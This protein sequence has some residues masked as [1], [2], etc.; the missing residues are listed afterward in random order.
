MNS[1]CADIILFPTFKWQISQPSLLHDTSDEFDK[2]VVNKFWIDIQ[3]RWGDYDSHDIQ[4]YA[5]AK[6]FEYTSDTMSLYP[7]PTGI[8]I[9]YDLAYNMCSA[10]GNW[11]PGLK[12]VVLEASN[13]ILKSNAALYVLRERV[14]KAL[15][16]YSSE[17]QVSYLNS[18]NYA[19]MFSDQT[20]W[21]I[22]DSNVYRVL[23]HK[24]L[25]GNLS[26]KPVNGVL[27]IFVPKTGRLFM[28]V[29]HTSVWAGQK[30]LGQLAK[31]KTAE[32]LIALMRPLPPEDQPKQIIVMR[33]GLL[34]PL[35]MNMIDFPNVIIKGSELQ[36]PFQSL[37]KLEIF[38]ETIT[39]A[40]EPKMILFNMYDDWLDTVSNYTAFSRLVLIMRALH[41]NADKT[42]LAMR[43]AASAPKQPNHIWPTLTQDEWPNVEIELRNIILADF[44]KSC[45][46]NISSLTQS[47]IKDIILGLETAKESINN[48][49]IEEIDRQRNEAMGVMQ[50]VTETVNKLGEKV[51]VQTTTPY[52]QQKFKSQ[53]DWRNRAIAST[54]LN[55]R[56]NNISVNQVD[57]QTK[58]TV[59][60]E[61]MN[62]YVFAKNV[63]KRFI[64]ITDLKT[65]IAGL[66]FG[67]T[68]VIKKSAS[69]SVSVKEIRVILMVPQIGTFHSVNF[70][71]F[72]PTDN[73]ELEGLE[74]L[75]WIHTQANETSVLSPF[76]VVASAKIFESN[77][78]VELSNFV[79]ITVSFPPGVCSL[80]A[81]NVT[82]E[83]L[84]WG[85]DNIKKD[86]NEEAILQTYN[87]R[88][89][90]RC[91]V[92]LSS[93][94]AGFFMVPDNQIWNY[95]FI[96]IK[97]ENITQNLIGYSP[98]I[99]KNFY[100]PVH[101]IS[102]FVNFC[103]HNQTRETSKCN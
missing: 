45:N 58:N 76:D 93:N 68:A 10:Y 72:I 2:A 65:Q 53:N 13:Q 17:P 1:S 21:F 12:P 30:R 67:K 61:K 26:T 9:A 55:S 57:P 86:I 41:I 98:D 4:R 79:I 43:S 28:K 99:P 15:Q 80:T 37:M 66:L 50:T 38:G 47:E 91:P 82:Q 51:I 16:L 62:N 69:V 25:E 20:M 64:C 100:H 59:D 8:L 101:R 78:N 85:K 6:F 46:V 27:F 74:F 5:R 77:K 88:L 33:K 103:K 92:W 70:L 39:K 75:G 3:L 97:L 42:R 90:Q 54:F 102:H 63:L 40:T 22:D 24:T 94:F 35:E 18:T 49:Q 89:Y 44:A 36:I 96:G 56:A 71:S 95:N 81:F 7:S 60:L 11:Y 48:R 19:E 32:E 83:G 23:I 29:I 14:R 87:N 34:D 31:W 52:E 73:P 84:N